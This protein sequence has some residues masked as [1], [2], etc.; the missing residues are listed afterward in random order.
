MSRHRT[1][2]LAPGQDPVEALGRVLWQKRRD[3]GDEVVLRGYTAPRP[4]VALEVWRGGKA[5]SV[6]LAIT[7]L[8]EL[9]TAL[10]KAPRALG[11]ASEG[12]A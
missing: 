1:I 2:A 10:V 5:R 11:A 3:N 4:H 9:S 7:D 8:A 6:R 12:A